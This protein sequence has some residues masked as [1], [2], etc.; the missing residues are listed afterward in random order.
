MT[1][2]TMGGSGKVAAT[3]SSFCA[4]LD[5]PELAFAVGWTGTFEGVLAEVVAGLVTAGLDLGVGLLAEACG[6]GACF[7]TGL[8][9]SAAGLAAGDAC[10]EAA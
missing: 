8:V 7:F 4:F 3:S 5:L 1:R 2:L 9:G 10:L 6:A